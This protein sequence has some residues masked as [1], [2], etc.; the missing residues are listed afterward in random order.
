MQLLKGHR[1]GKA[2]KLLFIFRTVSKLALDVLHG[3]VPPLA[4]KRREFSCAVLA[5]ISV[6]QLA[7]SE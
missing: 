6:L 1:R 7:V 4:E 5:E 3:R 2:G